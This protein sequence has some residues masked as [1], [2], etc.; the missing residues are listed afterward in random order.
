[1]WIRS[2]YKANEIR[3]KYVR[4]TN[5]PKTTSEKLEDVEIGE[6]ATERDV[7]L[8]MDIRKNN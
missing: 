7:S 4:N 8:K 3:I 1:M 2:G 6:Y 5:K